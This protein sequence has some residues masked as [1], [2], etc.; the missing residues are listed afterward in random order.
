MATIDL[1]AYTTKIKDLEMAIYTQRN[2]MDSH[3]ELLKSQ[4]PKA[5]TPTTPIRMPAPPVKP[6]IDTDFVPEGSGGL[7]L[8]VC[9]GI[10]FLFL[11]I[12][13]VSNPDKF[14]EMEFDIIV[15]F[16]ILWGIISILLF[17]GF[18][19]D[20]RRR[21][22]LVAPAEKEYERKLAEYPGIIA[23]YERRN[24]QIEE[25][26]KKTLAYYNET[27]LPQFEDVYKRTMKQHKETLAS[28]ENAL[29]E[30][31]NKDIVYPKYRNIVAIAAINEYLMSGRCDSLE[32]PNGAYNLYEME[33]RQDIVIGQLSVI[34]HNL[35]QIRDNQYTLYTELLRA[36]ATVDDILSEIK[37][38]KND[39]KLIKHFS[40][41]SVLA[42]TAPRLTYEL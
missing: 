41:L 20:H 42:Q 8:A 31:Y 37:V 7:F 3:K 12:L 25:N 24:I 32:G 17:I 14:E 9:G 40:E 18:I 15:L 27:V 35:E 23:D 39:T 34:I 5:P 6:K 1:K 4:R 10:L 28:L 11:Y 13:I 29:V 19:H 36:N 16:G 30:M 2:L 33:L 26:N 22:K 21:K 38:M